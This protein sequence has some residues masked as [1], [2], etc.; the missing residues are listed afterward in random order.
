MRRRMMMGGGGEKGLP[1][2]LRFTALDDGTFTLTIGANVPTSSLSYVEYSTDNGETWTRTN[3]V[4]SETISVTTPTILSGNSVV[5]RGVGSRTSESTANP[6]TGNDCY[7]SSSSDF[8]ASGCLCSLLQGVNVSKYYTLPD[9]LRTFLG[10]FF[11]CSTL[12]NA[13]DLKLANNVKDSCYSS[14]FRKCTRLLTAP[15]FPALKATTSSY[16]SAFRE[17]YSLVSSPY[18]MAT[19]GVGNY[20]CANM[21]YSCSKMSYIKAMFK[22]RP[23]S[24]AFGNWVTNV[25]SSGIF[26][27]HI[28]ATW[29]ITG[30]S[31]VPE[32]WT[33]IY[34]DP[35]EDKYYTSQDKSQ[36]C[37]DHGNPI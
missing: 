24:T 12:R 15:V 7:F 2:Y 27:K 34:Y 9:G 31:G 1:N 36:E 37:D 21:F 22:V 6:S 35:D 8:N 13:E 32:G 14:L 4:D 11:N 30:K 23:S 20:I 17:C 3:N 28:D 5:W 16:S 25:S 29:D 10:L 18:I 26:V 33:I 19:S